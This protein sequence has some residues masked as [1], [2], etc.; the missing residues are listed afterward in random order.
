MYLKWNTFYTTERGH[1]A[2]STGGMTDTSSFSLNN[3][4]ITY[5]IDKISPRPILFIT[6]DIA[7]SKSFSETVYNNALNPKE[8]YVVE[9]N[10]MHIYLYD[11]TTKIPIDKIEEFLNS[12]LDE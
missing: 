9:G 11:D 3:F 5:H 12:Y 10:I 1:H 2:R 6:G 8:L 7:H 4:P